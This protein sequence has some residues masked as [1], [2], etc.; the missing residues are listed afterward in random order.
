MHVEFLS[1]LERVIYREMY[2]NRYGQLAFQYLP[3]QAGL[4]TALISAMIEAYRDRKV[5]FST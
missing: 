4:T 3:R 1:Q 2:V 5:Q